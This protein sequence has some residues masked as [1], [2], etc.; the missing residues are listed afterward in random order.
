VSRAGRNRPGA[1]G[2][3]WRP[4]EVRRRAD[5]MAALLDETAPRAARG[6][7]RRA[8]A[9][10]AAVAAFGALSV[11]G[12]GLALGLTPTGVEGI[13]PASPAP[14]LADPASPLPT[15]TPDGDAGNTAS[16]GSVAAPAI[17]DLI[18]TDDHRTPGDAVAP[19]PAGHTS[20]D[21]PSRTRAPRPTNGR[22]TSTST[23]PRTT[24][25]R[26]TPTSARSATPRPT[27]TRSASPRAASTRPAAGRTSSATPRPAAQR[28][29]PVP[30]T[31]AGHRG[32]TPP[33]P[34]PPE[35]STAAGSTSTPTGDASE[36]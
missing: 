27:T 5:E 35:P 3:R 28:S 6:R 8:T 13:L 24:S 14:A 17:A 33:E 22:P 16:G 2:R 20:I 11:G 9:V 4:A 15:T 26:A 12:V 31:A 1:D 29:A 18:R 23:H 32:P 36:E 34:T 10:P 30:T 7:R 21:P 25:S 19:V